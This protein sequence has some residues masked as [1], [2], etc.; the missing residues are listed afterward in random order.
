MHL[1]SSGLTHKGRV[2]DDNQDSIYYNHNESFNHPIYIVADGMG[3]AKGGKTAS[4]MA[5]SIVPR[6]FKNSLA[7]MNPEQALRH[8]VESANRQIHERSLED[9]FLRGM[10][11]TLVGL[12]MLENN[13]AMVVNVGDSRCYLFRKGELH[14]VT[15]DHSLVQ[16]MVRKGQISVEQAREHNMRNM[17]SRALGTS[18]E[19]SPDLFH[20][21]ELETD[22]VFLLCSDGLHGVVS[23]EQMKGIL[24]QSSDISEKTKQFVQA[25]LDS[26]GPDNISA[27]LVRIVEKKNSG[28]SDTSQ[29][30]TLNTTVS[31]IQGLPDEKWNISKMFRRL[32]S[33]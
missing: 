29:E 9:Q 28:F 12:F 7:G 25:A 31:K 6:V 16:E 14:Q 15:E 27:V 3:G 21:K 32:L 17:L 20:I 10:G 19:V 24:A 22:D 18:P 26:G 1:S 11:T 13:T 8:A 30:I 2:R 4:S 23:T 33:R 5:T